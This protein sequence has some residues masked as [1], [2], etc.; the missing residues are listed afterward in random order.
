M[1]IKKNEIFPEPREN[2]QFWKNDSDKWLWI[3][4]RYIKHLDSEMANCPYLGRRSDTPKQK[5]KQKRS[6][7]TTGKL[8]LPFN[9]SIILFIIVQCTIPQRVKF[10]VL[11]CELKLPRK[12]FMSR[13]RKWSQ[14]VMKR[15]A[16]C[17]FHLWTFEPARP[18]PEL[19][20]LLTVAT[21]SPA[22]FILKGT[23]LFH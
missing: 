19:Y 14:E 21:K 15:F 17:S 3:P 23:N 13:E 22:L 4:N 2:S 6:F 1:F 9:S 16:L 8:A 5:Q 18:H 7:Y 12:S 10:I 11:V 20:F